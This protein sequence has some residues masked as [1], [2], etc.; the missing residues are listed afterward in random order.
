MKVFIDIETIPGQKDDLKAEIAAQ[1]PEVPPYEEPKCPR[2][3]KKP[4]TI[5]EWQENTLPGLRETAI[6][7]HQEAVDQRQAAIEEAWRKTGLYGDQGEIVCVSWA[8]EDAEPSV[9]FRSLG[10][11]EIDLLTMFYKSI[12]TQLNK[13]HPNWIGHNI[14]FD[15]RFLFHRSVILGIRPYV[16]LHLDAKPW[17]EQVQDTMIMWAGM[18][19]KISLDRI[20]KALGIQC[21]GADLPDGEYIDG[22]MV[23]DFVK[24]GEIA[25]VA[26]YCKA[27]VVR[28]RE[29]YKRMTFVQQIAMTVNSLVNQ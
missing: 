28:C 20:C 18:R 17:S 25:K 27:D 12:Y 19:D 15:L 8:I 29:A 23:W 4:E 14:T 2:N 11:S 10:E 5:K 16:N 22:S 3:I 9:V 13:R 26:A 7:K 21:K 1:F 24:R 6:L